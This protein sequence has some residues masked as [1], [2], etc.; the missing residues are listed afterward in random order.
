MLG[1][2]KGDSGTCKLERDQASAQEDQ[3]FREK[4]LALEKRHIAL[5]KRMVEAYEPQASMVARAVEAVE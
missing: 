1:L 5:L 2:A 4:L 3:A